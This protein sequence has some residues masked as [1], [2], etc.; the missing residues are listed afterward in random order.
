MA[1]CKHEDECIS[2]ANGTKPHDARKP[3]K[4]GSERNQWERQ[5]LA[6]SNGQNHSPGFAPSI[7]A[8]GRSSGSPSS[9]SVLAFPCIA[10]WRMNKFVRLTA[11]GAAPDW[12][13]MHISRVTGFPFHPPA[14][15]QEGTMRV[16]GECTLIVAGDQRCDGLRLV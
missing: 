7:N 4:A 9:S 8:H 1:V 5:E 16:R 11:A 13:E 2:T 14:D 6:K 10:Q 15:K 3:T 12:R